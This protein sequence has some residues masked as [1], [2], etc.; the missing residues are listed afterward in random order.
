MAFEP[1]EFSA[2]RPAPLGDAGG[3]GG[4]VAANGTETI[5]GGGYVYLRL[6]TGDIAVI[7]GKP[8]TGTKK[9]A[10]EGY[11]LP[12]DVVKYGTT[13]W[14]AIDRQLKGFTSPSKPS[15]PSPVS[16]AAPQLPAIVPQE[17]LAVASEGMA[18]GTKVAIGLGI[19]AISGVGLWYAFGGS[20]PEMNV[21]RFVGGS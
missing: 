12:L 7:K 6:S 19:L 11:S 13:A 20:M 15:S 8:P 4:K 18:T 10:V 2:H 16:A 5:G 9:V 14:T 1:S 3:A 21:K 17:E